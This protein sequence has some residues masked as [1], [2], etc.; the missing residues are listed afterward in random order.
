MIGEIT[1]GFTTYNAHTSTFM[2]LQES[3]LFMWQVPEYFRALDRGTVRNTG[4]G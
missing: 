4:P 3:T 2:Q 1:S